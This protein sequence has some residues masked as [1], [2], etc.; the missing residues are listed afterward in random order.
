M[1]TS[2]DWKVGRG[3]PEFH[4]ILD[5]A[6]LSFPFHF[7]LGN[8]D[9]REV[10]YKTLGLQRNPEQSKVQRHVSIIDLESVR[11]IVLDSLMYVNKTAGYLG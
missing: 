1:A 9:D 2:R 6:K 11:W 4:E 8:H 3:L 5:D 7:A 10:F